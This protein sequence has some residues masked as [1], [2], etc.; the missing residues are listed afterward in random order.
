M[1]GNP[2]SGSLFVSAPIAGVPD[3][4]SGGAFGPE[5]SLSGIVI[6]L[7]VFL[8]VLAAARRRATC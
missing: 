8:V 3:W 6:G 4:V 1:S 5:A 2:E 7:A